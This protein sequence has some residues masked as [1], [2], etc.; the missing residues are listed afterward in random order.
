MLI[1]QA[2]VTVDEKNVTSDEEIMKVENQYW[3]DLANDLRSLEDD[4]R[5]KRVI[6][7]GYFKDKAINGVSMLAVDHVKRNGLR[8]D[9]ME[10][11]VAIS[12]LEDYFMTIKS[13]GTI[14]PEDDEDVEE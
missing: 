2:Q 6:L 5:F 8:P 11:L 10:Q 7:Q 12:Q 3:V 14:P 13:L 4:P 9:I 1:N